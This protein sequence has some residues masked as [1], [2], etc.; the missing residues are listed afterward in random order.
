MSGIRIEDLHVSI[1]GRA[2]VDIGM[3]DIQSSTTTAL[4]GPSGCGKSTLLGAVCGIVEADRGRILVG[5]IDVT[6]VPTHRRGIG[7]VFQDNQLFPHLSVEQ[8]VAYGLRFHGVKAPD[9]KQRVHEMLALVGLD[10]F[11]Q[12]SVTNLSGGEAKRV[13][14]ARALAVQPQVLLLDEPLSALDADLRDRL[15]DDLVTLLSQL[16]MTC[17]WVTHDLAEARRVATSIRRMNER[18]S[19]LDEPVHRTAWRVV[20]IAAHD[21]HDLRRS[22]LRDGTPTT[23][24]VFEGDD[25][26]LHFAA[27]DD[28]GRIGAIASWFLRERT[29]SAQRG[30]QLRGMASEPEFRGSGAA[31]SLLRAGDGLAQSVGATEIWARARDTALGFYERHGFIIVG[32][33]YLDATTGLAHHDIT[34]QVR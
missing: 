25:T 31:S 26:A 15:L 11:E 12:R 34:R 23:D 28:S 3:L 1:D 9:A 22:V 17:L 13:A 5:G 29:G 14:L 19:L 18:G 16:G 20:P 4:T 8:N 7:L 24:V 30:L 21:T 33:G 2:I 6:N 10:G 32:E 27:V